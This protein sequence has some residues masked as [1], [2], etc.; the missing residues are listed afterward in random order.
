[1]DNAKIRG[2]VLRGISEP[3]V[4]DCFDSVVKQLTW[5]SEEKVTRMRLPKL[6]AASLSARHASCS[7]LVFQHHVSSLEPTNL[8]P[9]GILTTVG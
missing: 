5:S 1:M 4:Q 3:G 7:R 6:Q 9:F 8:I 2:T